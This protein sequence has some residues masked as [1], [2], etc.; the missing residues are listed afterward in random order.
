[1]KLKSLILTLLIS[2]GWAGIAFADAGYDAYEKED[3]SEAYRIW[4]PKANNGDARAQ[5]G[6]G[7]LYY[8]GYG[9]LRSES[10]GLEWITKAAEQGQASAQYA[11]AAFEAH[12]C[13]PSFEVDIGEYASQWC[14]LSKAKYWA[15]Q[16]YNNED[17]SYKAK[18]KK[19]W[20]KFHLWEHKD[21]FEKQQQ[22]R[23]EEGATLFKKVK[24]WLD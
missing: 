16:A 7:I 18:A 22:K 20:D 23:K 21:H 13:L 2:T 5:N 10:K 9:V 8:Y 17:S 3:Y 4:K 11:L 6:I 15:N 1:M 24:S 12:D 14:Y 19:L